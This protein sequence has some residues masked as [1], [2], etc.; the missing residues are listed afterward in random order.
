MRILECVHAF[1]GVVRQDRVARERDRRRDHVVVFLQA[2]DGGFLG[3]REVEGPWRVSHALR[4]PQP[5][6]IGARDIIERRPGRLETMHCPH[7]G[8]CGGWW[9]LS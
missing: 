8:V 4:L 6:R 1:N 7:I 5:F 9:R 2:G 3:F